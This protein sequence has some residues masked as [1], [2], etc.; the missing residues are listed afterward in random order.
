MERPHS[1]GKQHQPQ[2]SRTYHVHIKALQTEESAS[3]C[4]KTSSEED[5]NNCY[6][7]IDETLGKSKHYTIVMGD[8]NAQKEKRANPMETV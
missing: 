1:E 6:N 8:F 5:I 4:T 2:R 3:V 7:D